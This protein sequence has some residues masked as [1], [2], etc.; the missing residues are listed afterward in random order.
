MTDLHRRP[1]LLVGWLTPFYDLFARW[2]IPEQTLKCRLVT[3]ARLGGDQ[4]VLD[5]GAG[6]GTLAIQIAQ[7]RPGARVVALDGDPQILALAR[8]KASRA[9]VGIA[10]EV[11]SAVALP[12]ADGA[13]DRVV[14]SLV[15]SLLG[16]EA[17]RL[18][19]GEAYRVLVDGGEAH[20]ADFGPAHTR[21]ARWVAPIVRRFE[22][23]A[24]NLAGQ[25]PHM[26]RE[27]GFESV[28]E[29]DRL[30]SLFGTLSIVSGRKRG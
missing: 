2:F 11:G 13:F 24:G 23:I 18:A 17:K 9:G 30:G 29:G 5:L 16:D 8:G 4:R 28:S 20:I 27:A 15:F 19:I 14:S 3:R 10:L 22:P 12:H 7:T 6:T 26:L 21:W 1:A 25:L